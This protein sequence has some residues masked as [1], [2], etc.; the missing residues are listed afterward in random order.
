[1]VTVAATELVTVVLPE[2]TDVT[3][4]TLCIVYQ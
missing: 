3:V 2:S 4:S 1:M